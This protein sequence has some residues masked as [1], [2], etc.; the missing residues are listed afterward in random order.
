MKNRPTFIKN[1]TRFTVLL[2]LCLALFHAYFI[3]MGLSP[4]GRAGGGFQLLENFDNLRTG[5]V[6]NQANWSA[7]EPGAAEGALVDADPPIYFSGKAL[8]NRPANII[9]SGN[10]FLRLGSNAVGANAVGTLYFQLAVD[11][12]NQTNVS[13]GLSDVV[14]PNIFTAAGLDDLAAEI[15]VGGAGLRVR[16]GGA[17]QSITNIALQSNTLYHIWLVL[18]NGDNS[19]QL[20]VEGGAYSAPTLASSESQERFNFGH[21]TSGALVSF[22]I[23]NV[24]L[25]SGDSYI[26]SLYIDT[27]SAN[28]AHPGPH[29]QLVERF[30]ALGQGAIHGKG[31]WSAIG[32]ASV[33]DDPN[34]NGNAVLQLAGGNAAAHKALPAPLAQGELG[35]LHFRLRRDGAVDGFGGLS[36]EA[37]PTDFAAFETQ[38]G[39]QETAPD[40]FR[41][42]DGANFASLN[43]AFAN[44]TWYCIWLVMNNSADTYE[45]YVRGGDLRQVTQLEGGGKGQFA[46]RNG[47]ANPLTT[48]LA[49]TGSSGSQHL[50][51][52]DIYIDTAQMNLGAPGRD[53]E[54]TAPDEA[55]TNPFPEKLY[56]DGAAVQFEVI[57]TAPQSASGSI[58]PRTNPR[59]RLNFGYH[60]R[61]GSGRLF[62]NDLRGQLH[63]INLGTQNISEYLD[64]K[65]EFPEWL[66]SPGLN[67]GFS[68]FAFH[69][70]F[71]NNGLFYTIHTEEPNGAPDYDTPNPRPADAQG[72]LVEWKAN[73]PSANSFT[74]SHR[75]VLRVE[76]A[77]TSHGM[78]LVQFNPLARPGDADYGMLYLSNGDGE[79]NPLFS[80]APQHLGSVQ[81]TILRI[82]PLGNNS[83]NGK[84][85]IPAD[86]PFASSSDPNV[87]KE[88]YAYGFRNPNRFTWDTGG[89][90]KMILAEIGQ[91]LVE[92]INLIV[93]GRNYGWNI[94]EGTFRFDTDTPEE[95]YPLPP[96]D[97]GLDLTYPV[98]QFDH[99]EGFAIM[100]G[101]VYRGAL[102]PELDGVYIFGDIVDGTLF[103]V[104]V[105]ELIQGQQAP[106]HRL[107]LLNEQNNVVN[108][109]Q[110]VHPSNQRGDLRFAL[111]EAGE[112]YIMSKQDG[113]IRKLV[114][115]RAAPR[116]VVISAITRLSTDSAY[117]H[118][119]IAAAIGA[120]PYSDEDF[121]I[122]TLP[123]ELAG[124]DLLVTLNRENNISENIHLGFQIA[125]TARIYVA[126]DSRGGVPGWLSGWSK[127]G[128]Q[129]EVNTGGGSLLYQL[130]SR[131]FQAGEVRLGGNR[132]NLSTSVNAAGSSNNY[133]VFAKAV[134]TVAP[135]PTATSSGATSTPTA[136]SVVATATPRPTNTSVPVETNTPVPAPSGQPTNTPVPVETNTPVPLPTG[137]GEEEHRV[138]LPFV[139]K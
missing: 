82:N 68:T 18:N 88:I 55:I 34:Q 60:S 130:Y 78:Q 119:I 40:Q 54:V 33:A 109:K 7:N 59:T 25:N 13:L 44:R 124:A 58:D 24:G 64:I 118:D 81:G 20:Y 91:N 137:A 65:D 117:Y 48:F 51:I 116:G 16:S 23:H 38:F 21:A 75:E 36:D 85:G 87:L 120:N 67:S 131:E 125:Q 127:L 114:A 4:T 79:S 32:N 26:D 83:P 76:Q 62:V 77:F 98:A 133:F 112:I 74:G 122:T 52:D 86:N 66:E 15:N 108:F 2:L 19:F 115:A 97:D 10:A 28:L 126:L 41:A 43:S 71:K 35:T 134:N 31:G 84:Y 47:G 92:E 70:D 104:K 6:D 101:F 1:S 3:F 42:R 110:L 5:N 30:D 9:S 57:A 8:R 63:V 96:N 123:A 12:L 107:A 129:V 102:M 113:V 103:Y 37:A 90:H 39:A 139:G 106:I 27:A 14:E 100:G 128:V 136:T 11:D 132:A 22:V 73:D 72:V 56:H 45:V 105:D 17:Y 121:T 99:D 138:L 80:N 49:L 135:T 95:I 93:P 50:Y 111:D 94:R 46:F 61:D 69:P 29:F 53:C 89:E